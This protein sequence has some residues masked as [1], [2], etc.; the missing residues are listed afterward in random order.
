MARKDSLHVVLLIAAIVLIAWML[1]KPCSK[2]GCDV[3]PVQ[4]PVREYGPIA[5]AVRDTTPQERQ[6]Y[7]DNLMDRFSRN[8]SL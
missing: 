3:M 7:S 1:L 8:F 2:M 6:V 5:G 4:G